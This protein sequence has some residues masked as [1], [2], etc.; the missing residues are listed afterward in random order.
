MHTGR[1]QFIT[2]SEFSQHKTS[3]AEC[4]AARNERGVQEKESTI[5]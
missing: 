3:F 4:R 1:K 2:G 5:L